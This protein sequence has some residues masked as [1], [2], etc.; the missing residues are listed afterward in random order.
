[1]LCF[2]LY[3]YRREFV[4]DDIGWPNGLSI[5]WLVEELYWTDAKMNVIHAIDLQGKNKRTVV[6]GDGK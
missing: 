5:D 2:Y 6:S 1:M 4:T 3:F